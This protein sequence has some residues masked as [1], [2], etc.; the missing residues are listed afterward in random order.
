MRRLCIA[1]VF[2]L[3]YSSGFAQTRLIP[4]SHEA[5]RYVGR[6]DFSNPQEVSYDW[7]GVY[8]QFRF[9]GSEC[10]V[11][12]SDT[13]HNYYNVFI[14]DQPSKTF[15]VKSD[16]T[17]VIASGL[18]TQIH[19]VQ[20]YK[21]TEG[22]QGT[23]TFKGVLIPDNGELLPWKD[24]PTRKIEFIGNSIT[25]GYGTEGLSKTERW[26]PSTENNYLSYSSI[27]ARALKADYHIVAHSGL[28]V[29]RNYGYKEKVSPSAMPDRFNRVYDEKEQ[30][31]WNFKQW[32][33]DAVVINLGTNDFTT[34]PF[35]DKDVFKAGYEKLINEVRKQYGELPVFCVVGPMIDEPC[36]SYVKEMVEDFRT[37]YQ[38]KN[39]Y[40]VGIPTYL[41]N[42]EKDL[43]SDSHPNY[44]GQKKMAAHVLP[45]VASILD[46][47]Y[48]DSE[49]W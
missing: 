43:G 20:I 23:G 3:I 36:F 27:M 4:A 28:G 2:L 34:K 5:I 17:L 32:K 46:W 13:G 12:M 31:V 29:V 8:I 44:R 48:Q 21:R 10:A 25:C 41:L 16:T 37:I 40:F 42:P 26:K 7:S 35:P 49:L 1:I 14:D 24:V 22:N 15:D 45:L 33:P 30:P 9:R 47:D 18:G 38:K 11:K 39:V 6:F 19:R